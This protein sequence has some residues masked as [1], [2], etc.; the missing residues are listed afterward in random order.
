M[1]FVSSNYTNST[2]EADNTAHV[3]NNAHTQGNIV[4][5]T[6][7]D[8]LSDAVI[9]AFLASQ[10]NSP[11]L[12]KEDLEQIDPGDLEEMDLYW[13]MAMLTIRA[14]RFIQRTSKKEYRAPKNQ[15]N[16]GREYA[17]KIMPVENSTENTLIAQDRIGGYDWSYQV[18]EE[19]PTHYALIALT[20][21]RSSSS[22]DFKNQENVKSRSDKGYHVVPLPYTRT[23]MPPKHDLVLIDEQVESE[24]MYVIYN[25]T[26]SNVKTVESKLESVDV[27][28]KSVNSIGET[29]PIRQNSFSPPIIKDWNSDDDS[30]IEVKP[31]VEVKIVRPSIEKIKFVKTT[32]ETVKNVETPKQHKHYPRGNQRNWNN[33]MVKDSTARGR[34]VASGNMGKEGNPQQKEYKEKGLID[35]GCSRHMI[36]NKCY[37]AE[38]ED[39]DGG[40]VSFGDGKGR[41]SR[42]G[43]IK[44][45][46]L[47]FD[48]VYFY[49]ELKYNLFSVSQMCDKKNNFIFTDTECLVLS[50]NFK[51]LDE[52]QVLLGVPRK[53]NIYSVDLKSVVPTR[54]LTCLFAKATIDESILWYRRLRN[55]NYKTMN[56]FMRGNL[57]RSLPLKIF[58]NDNSCVACQK[59]NQNKASY[60]AKLVN[61]ISKPLHMLHMDLFGPINVK[62]LMK[63]SYCLVVT[64]DFSRFFWVFFLATKCETSKILK[65]FIIERENQLDC[66]VKVIRRDNGTEF[67]NSVMNQFYEDKGI[68]REYS[69]ARTP[70]HNR[71]AE[72]KNKTLIE[73]VKTMLVDSKLPTTFWAEAVNTACYVLNRALVTKPHNKTPYELI[74]GRPPL[75][76][77]MKPFG[78][79]VTILN[80]QDN[81]GK[82][83]GKADEGF[84]IGYSV[85]SKAMRVFNKRTRIVEETLNIIFLKN[86][87][88][89]KGNRPNWLFDIDSLTV[90][91]N[92]VPVVT[93]NQTNGIA[94]TRDNLITVQRMMKKKATKV[95]ESEASDNGGQDDQVTRSEF[96]RLLQ[97]ERQTEHPNRTNSF[98]IVSS[99]VSTAEPSYVNAASPSLVIAVETPASTNAFEEHPFKRFSSFKNAFSLPHV[100]NKTPI[101]DTSIFG[102]AYNDTG[103]EEEVDMNNFR[104]ACA[105][106]T[107]VQDNE[108]FDKWAIGIKWVFRNKKDKRGIVVKNKVRLVAQ[109][110]TQEEGIDYDEVFAPV[111]RIKAIRLFLPYASFKDFI[112]YQMD[113]NSAFLYEKIKEE[114]TSTLMETNKP[115]IKDEEAKDVDVHLYRSMIGSLMYLIACRPDNTFTVC[116]CA[117]FQVTPKTSHLHAVKIIFRYLKGQPKLGLWYLKD[118]PFDLEAFSDSD[119]VGASLDRKSTTGGCQFLGKRLMIAKDG[120]CFVDTFEVN[121]GKKVNVQEHI[122]ALVDKKKVIIME[123]SIRRDLRFNDAEGTPCLLNDSIFQGLARMGTM[124]SAIICLANKQKFNFSK[125]IFDNMVKSL[126]GGVKFYMFPRFLQVFLDKQVEGMARHKE[127][128]VISS[129]TKTIFANMRR[130]KACFSGRKQKP[131]RKQRKEAEVPHDES[132][133]EEDVPILSS[134]PLPSCK[135]SLQLNELMVFCTSL[136]QQVLDL[137][138]EKAAQAKEIATLKK[139]VKKLENRKTSRPTGLRRLKKVGSSRRVKSSEEKDEIALDDEAQ[140]RTNDDDMF[141][142]DDLAGKE[143]VMDT[144]TSEHVEHVIKGIE[145]RSAEPV[146]TAGEV[147]TTVSV[148]VSV[149]PTTDVTEDEIT[150]AQVL[151]GLKSKAIMVEPEKPLKKK[152]KIEFDEE[153]ARKLEAK[154]QE[155]ARLR[156]AQQD[157]EAN[158][159]WD[160]IQALM[161]VDRLLAKR[162][163]EREREEFSEA[164]KAIL[165]IEL[166]EKIKKHFAALRAQEKI[167]RPPTKV[168]ENVEPVIDDTEE[169]KRCIEIV[170]DDRDDVLVEATPLSSKSPTIIDYKNYREGKKHYYQ[171]IRADNT[172]VKNWKLFDSCEVYRIPMQ[173]T[174]DYDAE[175]AYDLLGFIK[176]QIMESYTP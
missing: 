40:F 42:K 44:T 100:P 156:I 34:V 137:Q 48:D 35:S 121:S 140:G 134:D 82:F 147:V 57:V 47:D 124:A 3:V 97:Q 157:E 43:K 68:K 102:N 23:Y 78:C 132:Q 63:K 85:V 92:Y 152:D 5:S 28:N 54:D 146:T 115:L 107:Y 165:L 130:V 123:D 30:E 31:K 174:V 91:I 109:G 95:D 144:T 75:I 73:A 176:K 61:S 125:Y 80:T 90:S 119:Y 19:H 105:D 50:S 112:V 122:Q 153:Y 1:A 26:S 117:R 65:T 169:L 7:V 88:N 9:C 113:V 154:E 164:Q 96:D 4:N 58:Q 161:N 77:S 86:V 94:G 66:K 162:L 71:V 56:K 104:N 2:N 18:E 99:P 111:A 39:Y 83:K 74:R 45:G 133:D 120:R 170:P 87:P 38:Y 141:G 114:T 16:R 69:V 110:H 62:S 158:I 15:E 37:L 51:L 76:D 160:N 72:R 64:D 12:A 11:Q 14:R 21:S 167:N 149:A 89:V 145:V 6:S 25:V 151:A 171:I 168:D 173:S 150:M 138:E 166:I 108:E 175:M 127:I 98:N 29:K 84:F 139:R 8:N 33:L 106:K 24:F 128:Y 103:V 17:R 10:P 129:H 81:L 22:S 60:K 70:Q 46:K 163:Q 79:P 49:K 131:R 126:E 20:S 41:I 53:D 118:S 32:K 172:M 93:R 116:A 27:K 159:S 59:G 143:V 136:L 55:I 148:K 155:A 13:K 101:N 36:G 52:S 142:I 135:D 67:K